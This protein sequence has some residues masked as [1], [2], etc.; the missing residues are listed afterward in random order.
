MVMSIS[1]G[2]EFDLPCKIIQ[3]Q[4]SLF[5]CPRSYTIMSLTIEYDNTPCKMKRDEKTPT[6]N[7]M[8]DSTT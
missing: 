7:S 5:M 8:L 2:C 6:Q 4:V 1:Y 3:L